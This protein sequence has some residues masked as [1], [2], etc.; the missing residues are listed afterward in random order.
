MVCL[1]GRPMVF[2]GL[3]ADTIGAT[4]QYRAFDSGRVA[5]QTRHV[6]QLSL[7]ICSY[8]HEKC[9]Q[10]NQLLRNELFDTDLRRNYIEGAA[11]ILERICIE[12]CVKVI[13]SPCFCTIK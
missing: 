4:L 9:A 12:I 3:G 2:P 6:M 13:L 5:A 7:E 8:L 11:P 10:M 1:S